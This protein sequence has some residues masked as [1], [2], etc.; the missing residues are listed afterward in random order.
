MCA[1]IGNV[2]EC[3][4]E[5]NDEGVSIRGRL[6]W[7]TIIVCP[8]CVA[9]IGASP[10]SVGGIVIPRAGGAGANGVGALETLKF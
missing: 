6:C 4:V 8:P 2:F 9:G 3:D 1:I 7:C 10:G 5:A